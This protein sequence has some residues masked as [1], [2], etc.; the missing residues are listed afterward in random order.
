MI[1]KA[2]LTPSAH[3]E[4]G[5]ITVPFPIPDGEYDQTI[6][7]LEGLGIGDALEQDCRVAEIESRFSVLRQIKQTSVT[8]DE[9]DYLA[10]RLD[11]FSQKETAQF[12]GVAARMGLTDVADL[13]DLTFCCQQA[14]VVTDFSNLDR[15]GRD[16]CLNLH[17]GAMPAEEYA[18]TDGTAEALKLFR[19]RAGVVTPYGVVFDNDM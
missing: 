7:L 12:Q 13:I 14:T 10:K 1:L 9:L 4:Y 5:E 2:V 6:E 8:V 19:D 15:I 18:G 17:G 3:P 16:H 11:S